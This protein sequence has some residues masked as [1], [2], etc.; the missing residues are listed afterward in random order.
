MRPLYN[1]SVMEMEAPLCSLDLD[2]RRAAWGQKR[3]PRFN[4]C[5]LPIEPWERTSPAPT[6]RSE[7]GQR[8]KSDQNRAAVH[9]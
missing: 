4:G 1:H 7:M 6:G 5:L 2:Q 9:H 8:P 3:P